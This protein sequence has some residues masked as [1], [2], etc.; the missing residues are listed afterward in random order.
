MCS[1]LDTQAVLRWLTLHCS[2]PVNTTQRTFTE[3]S[4]KIILNRL[5]GTGDLLR[6]WGEKKK[7]WNKK[8]GRK[9]PIKSGIRIIRDICFFFLLAL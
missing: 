3:F 7:N 9:K 6:L 4:F 5:T 1:L 2:M 8:G